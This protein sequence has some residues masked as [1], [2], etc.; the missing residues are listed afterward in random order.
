MIQHEDNE[1]IQL[2]S[3]SEAV[4]VN[5]NNSEYDNPTQA[6]NRSGSDNPTIVLHNQTIVELSWD[7]SPEQFKVT[8][9]SHRSQGGQGLLD[10]SLNN[11]VEI[12]DKR[13]RLYETPQGKRRRTVGS[14]RDLHTR[15]YSLTS[16]D[17]QDEMFVPKE[18]LSEQC[19]SSRFRRQEPIRKHK[20]I[21]S[22]NHQVLRNQSVIIS[23]SINVLLSAYLPSVQ[24][25][26][27]LTM[28]TTLQGKRLLYK[29]V[30]V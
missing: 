29:E 3:R 5:R 30:E 27:R 9:Y 26:S 10:E 4:H 11:V 20:R 28:K 21:L 1:G 23:I 22:Q 7:M 12:I 19:T 24:Q 25:S 14:F 16:T 13:N 17:S 8:F 15:N 6:G 2:D 18:Q